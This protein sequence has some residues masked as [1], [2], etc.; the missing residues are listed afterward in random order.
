[1]QTLKTSVL[2]TILLSYINS[3]HVT[4]CKTDHVHTKTE[5]HFIAEDHS[6]TQ[7]LRIYA[8]CPYWPV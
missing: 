2:I 8:Q 4:V 5:I 1:M 6:Y 7:E 3:L